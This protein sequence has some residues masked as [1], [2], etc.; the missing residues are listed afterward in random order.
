MCT[1]TFLSIHL[2][3][4]IA[5]VSSAAVNF[6]YTC[7]FR[8]YFLHPTPVFLPG[9]SYGQRSLVG[10]S[11]WSRRESDLP[12]ATS[13]ARTQSL[14]VSQTHNLSLAM[15]PVLLWVP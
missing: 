4:D 3:I 11:P 9:E 5:I 2:P 15:H 10:C 1:T 14:C 13:Y 8:F 12:E 7:L 6:G